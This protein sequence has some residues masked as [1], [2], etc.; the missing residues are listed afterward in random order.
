MMVPLN[1]DL[2]ADFSFSQFANLNSHKYSYVGLSVLGSCT[3]CSDVTET[4]S[5]PFKKNEK[6]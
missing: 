3:D 1:T 2:C 6:E 5:D 4:S